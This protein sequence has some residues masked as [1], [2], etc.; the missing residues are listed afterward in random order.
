MSRVVEHYVTETDTVPV[1]SARKGV[2]YALPPRAV[3]LLRQLEYI[4]PNTA[5]TAVLSDACDR[6]IDI[7]VAINDN[8]C[9]RQTAIVATLEGIKQTF[10]PSAVSVGCQLEDKT[11]AIAEAAEA[12]RHAA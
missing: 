10:A 11:T 9:W 5:L 1:R 7:A 6:T 8:A 4:A 3:G 2:E 12:V